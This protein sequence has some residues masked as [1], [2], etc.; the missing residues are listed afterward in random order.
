MSNISWSENHQGATIKEEASEEVLEID[1]KPIED[2]ISDID[3]ILPEL[4]KYV[5]NKPSN[6]AYSALIHLEQSLKLL[7]N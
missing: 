6:E 3:Q 2:I 7:D 1:L 5:E 4:S